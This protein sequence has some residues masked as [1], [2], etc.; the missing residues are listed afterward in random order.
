MSK[1]LQISIQSDQI[2][3]GSANYTLPNFPPSPEFPITVDR[4]GAPLNRVKDTKWN[5]VYMCNRSISLNFKS[6]TNGKMTKNITSNIEIFQHLITYLMYGTKSITISTVFYYFNKLNKVFRI[7]AKYDTPILEMHRFPILIDEVGRKLKQGGACHILLYLNA[8]KEHLGFEFLDTQSITRIFELAANK[9]NTQTPYIPERIW[10]YQITRLQHAI[11]EFNTNQKN[12][13]Q[14]FSYYL[15]VYRKDGLLDEAFLKED[16]YVSPLK[17]F[18]PNGSFHANAR[19]F[20]V[21]ELITRWTLSSES[22]PIASLNINSLSKYLGIVSRVALILIGNYTGMRKGELSTL[23]SVCFIH[24]YDEIYGD[25]YFIEGR[26]TKTIQ[27]DNARWA[28]PPE[29]KYPVQA[30][31]SIAKLRLD[32]AISNPLVNTENVKKEKFPLLLRS[33]EPWGGLKNNE[34]QLAINTE[35][36]LD[37]GLLIK[38]CPQLFD[39]AAITITDEDL[40]QARQVTPSLPPEYHVGAVWPFAMHQLRRTLIVNASYSGLVSGF[41]MQ[42]QM[43]HLFMAMTKHYAQNFTGKGIEREF[44][45]EFN[46]ALAEGFSKALAEIR[47]KQY[48]SP[49][50]D[51][52]KMLMTEFL[53]EKDTKALMKMIQSNGIPIRETLLGLCMS[54]LPCE[55]G[56]FD[57]ITNCSSCHEAAFNK[58]KEPALKRL[59][60]RLIDDLRNAPQ[61]HPVYDSLTKQLKAAKEIHHVMLA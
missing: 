34:K 7:A 3:P 9:E 4:L 15:D 33:Y 22:D 10:R 23:T 37:Y 49:Y 46:Q 6:H 57:S 24:E 39:R 54:R 17:Y 26:T 19:S 13:K 56:G 40:K 5:F 14:L 2:T 29:A 16:G 25:L 27:D 38:H 41:S 42:F 21:D 55:Y 44:Q 8:H 51:D 11:Q 52:H 28:V 18:H 36:T 43:K 30:L 59:I 1:A 61:D 45:I 48:F 32:C 12:I 31:I 50:G 35:I 60:I 47:S 20:G 53:T 58:Q